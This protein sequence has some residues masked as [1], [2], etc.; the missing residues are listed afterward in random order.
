MQY[1][2]KEVGQRLDV[3]VSTIRY[4]QNEFTAFVKPV[5]TNGGQR[6]YSEG[7]I[8]CF[9]QI[10]ELVYNKKITIE[11]AKMFLEKGGPDRKNFDW[12]RQ[13]ILL[14]GGTGAG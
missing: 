4:W 13:S 6:R 14:T 3:P 7:D 9:Q 2:I 12:S 11:H 8:V 10:K 5:R 1:R